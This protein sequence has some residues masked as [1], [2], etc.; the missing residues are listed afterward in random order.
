[1]NSS[2]SSSKAMPT[3]R[4][5]F[6]RI[7]LTILVGMGA[8]MGMVRGFTM[9]MGADAQ[10]L[11]GRVLE[12]QN[13]LKRILVEDEQD[14]V[15]VF[16]SSMVEAGFSPR[17]FDALIGEQGG[18]V[19]SWNYGFGGLNPVF[20]EILARR[21]ADDLRNND[22]RLK[23]LLIEFN[24]F[25]TTKTRRQRAEA[26]VEPYMSLLLSPAEIWDRTIEDPE[27]GIRIAGI[28]WLRD[29]VSAEA[30]TT[31]F[32]SEPFVEEEGELDPGI[33]PDEAIGKRIGEIGDE[34]FPLFEEEFPEFA[35]CDWCYD[36]KGGNALPS[37][38]SERLTA[39]LAEYYGLILNDYHMGR[40]RLRR[41]RTADI[42]EL[43]F[44]ENLV[45]GFIGMVNALKDVSDNIEV[46]MLPKNDGYI[47]NPPEAIAR[48]NEVIARIER[49]TGVTVRDFQKID[50][51][52]NDMFSDTTHLNGLA[53]RDAFTRFLAEE[54]GHLLTD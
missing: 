40:D 23:L 30:I 44:D 36:W 21:F 24:P 27:S 37:E 14:L 6:L 53:G 2:T 34:Y 22:R 45:V 5:I 3:Q 47:K 52:S 41:I 26:L 20:Q 28:R 31:Y 25:Q 33:E 46:I 11:L 17:Q 38:R 7:F 29:G 13:G 51:V 54:Y 35:D 4:Q 48:Q 49:E 1:M 50:A 9:A 16:G 12:G 18:N 19:S 43:D 42:E 10:E 39:L 8:A 15:M 32:L